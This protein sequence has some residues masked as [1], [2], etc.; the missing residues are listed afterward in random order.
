MSPQVLQQG[1]WGQDRGSVLQGL[2]LFRLG[3]LGSPRAQGAPAALPPLKASS[4]G[5]GADVWEGRGLQHLTSGTRKISGGYSWIPAGE[6]CSISGGYSP[7]PSVF[8]SPLPTLFPAA[9]SWEEREVPLRDA[10]QA[11]IPEQREQS[12]EHPPSVRGPAAPV[13]APGVCEL[14]LSPR[15]SLHPPQAN[16]DIPSF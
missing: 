8:L 13:C 10:D 16:N 3:L 1:V 7:S 15:P 6:L 11:G 14:G 4:N 12:Q 2:V 5:V 9:E